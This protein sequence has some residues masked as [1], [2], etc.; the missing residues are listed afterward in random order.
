[1]ARRILEKWEISIN[2]PQG[3]NQGDFRVS[4]FWDLYFRSLKGFR[5]VWS[6]SKS[7]R[8]PNYQISNPIKTNHFFYCLIFEEFEKKILNQEFYDQLPEQVWSKG[9]FDFSKIK[10][11]GVP[12]SLI[13]M[14]S[15]RKE[16]LSRWIYYQQ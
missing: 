8:I 13:Q 15:K 11:L 2:V 6:Y 10:P 16:C 3:I 12:S 4:W 7:W 1:M 14:V 5:Q 9:S